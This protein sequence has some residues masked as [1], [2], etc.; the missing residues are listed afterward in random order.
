MTDNLK[1]YYELAKELVAREDAKNNL[2]SFITYTKPDFEVGDHHFVIADALESVSRGECDRLIIEAPPRHGKSEMAS[3]RYVAWEMG[4]NPYQQIIS[5]TYNG[6]LANTIGYEVRDIIRDERYANV[7][8]S[9]SLAPDS[10]AVGLWRTTANGRKAGI[11]ASVGVGGAITGRGAHKAIIDDPVKNRDDA[12]S[13]LMRD[14]VWKWYRST[15]YT[16]LMPNAAII[17]MMTRWH[18]DDLAG[19]LLKAQDEDGDTWKLVELPAINYKGEALWPRWYSI[20][21][22]NRIKNSVG[23]REWSALYMQRPSPEEGDFF[24]R[25]WFKRHDTTPELNR[26]MS[27]DYAVTEDGSDFTEHGVIGIDSD[28]NIYVDDWWYGKETA[29]KWIDAG[30]DLHKKHKPF[31][32]FGETGVIRRAIEPYLKRQMNDRKV[33]GR[34]EWIT[35]THNK[36]ISARAFQSLAASGKVS[37]RKSAWGDRLIEQLVT[38]PAGTNDDAVDVCS[39]FGMALDD[40]HP[41]IMSV[42]STNKKADRWDD[43]FNNSEE[44]DSWRTT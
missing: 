24:R 5:S 20:D 18:E 12:D 17:L 9:V 8:D 10:K 39:L 41:A 35:R 27:S 16:R 33:Y 31:A 23:G 44:E 28:W 43:V 13:K 25:E 30:I 42:E 29:D 14:K 34:L 4:K 15:L 19:R 21:A 6:D 22:L 3:R 11:Y 7:F 1:R 32:W 37:I 40:A 2:L 26:Y 38:F 36:V